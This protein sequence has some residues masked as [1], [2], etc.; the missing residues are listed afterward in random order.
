MYANLTVVFLFKK[1][2][3]ILEQVLVLNL[4]SEQKVFKELFFGFGVSI[5]ST[6]KFE[7]MLRIL[8]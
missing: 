2:I 4:R 5:K 8:R 6:L 7:N 1:N 3:E